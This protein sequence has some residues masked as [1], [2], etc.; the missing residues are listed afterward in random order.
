MGAPETAFGHRLD[1]LN[2][3]LDQHV[4]PYPVKYLTNRVTILATLC[5]LIPLIFFASNQAFVNAANSYLNVMSVA[6]SSIV[7]LYS[8]INEIRE[9]SAAQR[10]EEIARVQAEATE[11]RAQADHERIQ[12][13]HDHMDELR[14]EMA[15]H[16]TVSLDNIQKLLVDYLSKMQVED[17]RRMEATHQS[18]HQNTAAQNQEIAALKQLVATMH[19]HV[20][21]MLG[22]HG[23]D[24]THPHD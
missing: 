1:R 19:E 7:L 4:L 9:R 18:L 10:R 6:V 24:K 21:S 20:M 15:Q 12:Q 13:I 17:Q 22:G 14:E 2:A 5:L 8:T 16:V 23:L 3:F 11:K